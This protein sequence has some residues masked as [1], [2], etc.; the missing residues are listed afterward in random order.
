MKRFLGV[1]L[2]LFLTIVVFTQPT[3]AST[4]DFTISNFSAD[5]Y[6]SKDNEGRS[7]LKTIEK[8]TAE[9]PEINQ[10]HG[11]ERYLVKEYDGYS[12][13]LSVISI[14]D[15][16]SNRLN[17]SSSEQSGNLILRIGDSDTYVHGSQTYVITYTQRDVTKF[18]SNTN[19]DEFYWDING[20]NW[21]QPFGAV[22][23][24]LHL[25]L[26][27]L[28]DL[29]GNMACYF[30]ASGSDNE[31]EISLVGDVATA[32]VN[33]L[34]SYENMTIAVGF[35]P[36]TFTVY[37]K[38]LL[39]IIKE[40]LWVISISV[41]LLLLG[42]IIYLRLLKVK[43]APGRGVIVAEYLPPKDVD[44]ATA[45]IIAKKQTNWLAATCIDLAVRHNIRIIEQKNKSI[46]GKSEYSLEFLSANGLNKNETNIVEAMFGHNP[47]VGSNYKLSRYYPDEK[48]VEKINKVFLN[49]SS[50]M[51]D[52]EYYNPVKIVKSKMGRLVFCNIII[53]IISLALLPQTSQLSFAFVFLTG[54]ISTALGLVIVQSTQP[55]S[56][57]GRELS[58][59]LKGLELYIKIA[60][61]DRIKVLQS[62]Q[63]VEKTPVDVSDTKYLVHLYERVLPYAIIFGSE[64]E[65]VKVLGKYYELQ[66]ANPE[67]YA[68]NDIM[69]VA[70]FGSMMHNFSSSAINNSRM[71][72]SGGSSSFG[73]SGGG[74]FSGGGGGGGGG[75]GW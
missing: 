36:H 75:G 1:F 10:N 63:G 29:N 37:K 30:G 68:G 13:G 73:G 35:K 24:K 71:A 14:T 67:W 47:E 25:D 20:T 51:I 11:I 64:K 59:Y 43:N 62:P 2:A 4:N 12:T 70:L 33:N 34:A 32:S 53:T 42:L 19:D 7:T 56:V 52:G 72:A 3:A 65:W 31:C 17:Y 16:N 60:E 15:E 6:L 26:S 66:K 8:I 55:L 28:N 40:N 48:I 46:L 54:F 41:N 61:E 27:I 57:K 44:V 9:F 45:A 49:L 39:D 50:G 21:A 23:A 74:G 5:Y 69:N 22:T 18:F 58:D 38:S